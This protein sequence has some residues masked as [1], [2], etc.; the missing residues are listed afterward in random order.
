MNHNAEK[1]KTDYDPADKG[2]ISRFFKKSRSV[3]P[4]FCV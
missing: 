1:F 2:F 4:G 3:S